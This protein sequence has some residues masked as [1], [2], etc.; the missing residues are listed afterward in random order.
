MERK[1]LSNNV[2][3]DAVS[4]DHTHIFIFHEYFYGCINKCRFKIEIV[5]ISEDNKIS[6]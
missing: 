2:V 6:A 1:L 5:V 3:Y 4:A